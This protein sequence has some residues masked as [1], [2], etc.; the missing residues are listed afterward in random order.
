MPVTDYDDWCGF[1]AF[2]VT[3]LGGLFGL[4]FSCVQ[5][6]PHSSQR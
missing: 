2:T 1:S 6:C 4:A 5:T 3:G